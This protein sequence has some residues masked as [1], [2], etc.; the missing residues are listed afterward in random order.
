MFLSSLTGYR[1]PLNPEPA[2]RLDHQNMELSPSGSTLLTLY[3]NIS[4]INDHFQF[5][6]SAKNTHLSYSSVL[7]Q[8]I[9]DS[10]FFYIESGDG[11]IVCQSFEQKISGL[12]ELFKQHKGETITLSLAHSGYVESS[13]TGSIKEVNGQ[14]VILAL[15]SGGWKRFKLDQVLEVQGLPCPTLGPQKTQFKASYHSSKTEEVKGQVVYLT[16]GLQWN[17]HYRVIIKEEKD[18]KVKAHF[19]S[20]LELVNQTEKAFQDVLVQIV[21]GSLQLNSAPLPMP[22]NRMQACLSSEMAP[23]AAVVD[24]AWNDH[25][26]FLVPYKLTLKPFGHVFTTLFAPKEVELDKSYVISHQEHANGFNRPE[27]Q[28]ALNDAESFENALPK[29]SLQL[30]EQKEGRLHFMGQDHL[31][32]TP[33]GESFSF[34]TGRSYDLGVKR[35]TY[36][37]AIRDPNNKVFAEEITVHLELSNA[38]RSDQEMVLKEQLSGDITLIDSSF[39]LSLN[40]SQTELKVQVPAQTFTNKPLKISYTYRKNLMR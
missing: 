22:Y 4:Q 26:A 37:K 12:A 17:P 38:S 35:S 36:V 6:A 5:I 16:Q 7:S 39:K 9:K 40:G 19:L 32:S 29:G 15:S 28:Y 30:Y 27:I 21:S 3:E 31:K 13:V 25:K 14:E 23:G 10:A 18:S 24:Q 1:A 33:Q 34:K 8:A 11:Q 20:Q 2:A